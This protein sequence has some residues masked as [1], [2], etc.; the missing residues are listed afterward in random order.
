VALLDFGAHPLWANLLVF[1]V[2]AGIIWLTGTRLATYAD[3]IAE[4]TGLG[5]A[6][7]GLVLLATATSLPEI[8]TTATASLTGNAALAVN[9]IFGGIAMQTAILALADAAVARG[10]LTF[11]TPR[12]T[13]LLQGVTLVLL[14]ALAL[15]GIAAGPLLSVAGIGIWPLLIFLL[16]VA[17]LYVTHEYEGRARW[18]P[19]DPPP[20][21]ESSNE[22]A[23]TQQGLVDTRS[24][25]ALL[26][27]FLC[28]SGVLLVAG[29]T[30]A[31]VADALARQTGLGASFVGAT[32]VAISTSLPEV[33]TTIAAARLGSYS[34]AVSNIFGSNALLLALLFL[35]DLLYRQG[36]ILQAVDRSATFAAA[37]GIVVTSVYLLGLIE[38]LDRTVWRLGIDSAVVL[39]VYA[40]NLVVLYLLR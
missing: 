1:G 32:L 21:V 13:L 37:M 38:R 35:G 29:W 3:A 8:G 23:E 33:S 5:K 9:N 40:G 12:P 31:Q 11:F 28:G 7:I 4:R 27:R 26:L 16:Y 30:V 18:K 15:A 14:L 19:V 17:S 34:L 24:T 20:A 22:A 39:V 10:A 2:A 6:F 36:P 25:R